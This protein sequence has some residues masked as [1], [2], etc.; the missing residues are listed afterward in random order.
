ME[1]LFIISKKDSKRYIDG[2]IETVQ[3]FKP[4]L[5]ALYKT[6][7]DVIDISYDNQREVIKI[8]IEI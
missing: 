6:F 5:N 2:T 7:D 1:R 4:L 3:F 8:L